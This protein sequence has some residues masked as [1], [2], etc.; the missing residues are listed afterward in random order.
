MALGRE[1]ISKVANPE[2]DFFPQPPSFLPALA[3]PPPPNFVFRFAKC[4]SE[5]RGV[6]F[7]PPTR[8]HTTQTPL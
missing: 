2:K 8:A 5:K 4:A 3:F 1:K 6:V 7:A